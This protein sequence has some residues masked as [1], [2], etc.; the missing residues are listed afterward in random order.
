MESKE[1]YVS[2]SPHSFKKLQMAAADYFAQLLKMKMAA[3][4][5]FARLRS[6]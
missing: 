5:Y 3:A 2:G 4:D 6:C 1:N